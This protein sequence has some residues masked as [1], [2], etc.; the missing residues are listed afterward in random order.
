MKKVILLSLFITLFATLTAQ[1]R[2][3][4]YPDS[5]EE[6]ISGQ[7]QPGTFYVPRTN[8]AQ[9]D[10]LENG[11]H[12]N[13]IRINVLEGALNNT[14]NLTDCLSYL[15]LARNTLQQLPAKTD[16]LMFVIGKMPPWL[17]S[18]SDSSPSATPGWA[19]L[20]TRPPAS[21]SEWQTVVSALVDRIVNTYGISDAQF[22]IW[23]EPDLGSWTG[24]KAEY[25]RLYQVT[26]DAVKSVDP[27]L[28]VGGPSTN[29][30]ANNIGYQP[31]YGY[32]TDSTADLSLIGELIDS[33]TAWNKPMDF[34]SWHDFNVVHHPQLN[35]IDYIQRKYALLGL[36][37]PE[38]ILSEWN[39]PS[40]VRE[41]PLQKSFLLKNQLE[42]A[43]TDLGHNV[44][45]A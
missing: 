14:T 43:K 26:Y 8:E 35:A 18:S 44:I 36:P 38:L 5:L 23:N 2:I 42:L 15:D 29:Y 3:T 1:T 39:T 22:E 45:A 33:T 6:T 25:F 21:Y 7:F 30:W 28:R 19:I 31:P 20:H 17:S 34:I 13:A 41:T 11:I 32:L 4:V 24:T 10:F 12:Q 27:D 9:A 40:I 37:L 16:V